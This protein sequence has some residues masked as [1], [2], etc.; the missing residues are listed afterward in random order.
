VALEKRYLL[1][2]IFSINNGSSIRS[3]R[4]PGAFTLN[5]RLAHSICSRSFVWKANRAKSRVASRFSRSSGNPSRPCASPHV[6]LAMRQGRKPARLTSAPLGPESADGIRHSVRVLARALHDLRPQSLR[7]T[8]R[9]AAAFRAGTGGGRRQESQSVANCSAS[10]RSH[11]EF[12]VRR[13][14]PPISF[15]AQR[16]E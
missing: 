15:V 2:I 4:S 6:G 14:L 7:R 8:R 1:L 11:R 9:V 3:P 13:R 16:W 5:T 10:S 12:D